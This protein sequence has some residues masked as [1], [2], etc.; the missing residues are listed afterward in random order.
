MNAAGAIELTI[1]RIGSGGDGIAAGPVYVPGALPG[2]RILAT[3]VA[4]RRDAT[5]A[6]LDAVLE[7]SAERVPPPC[8]HVAEGC[9]G[10]AVQHWSAPAVAAWKRSRLIEAL[11]RAGFSDP[12]VA[13]TVTVPPR[14]RRRAD[15]ALRRAADGSVCAGLHIGGG[16]EVIAVPHCQVLDPRLVAL[17]APLGIMLRSLGALRREGSAIVNLLDDGPDLLLRTD[18]PLDAPGRALLAGFAE[19][20]GPPRIAWA[21][22]DGV[23][24]T[25]AQRVPARL[26]LS[27]VEVVVPPGAFLQAAPQGE[28]AIIDAVLAGLPKK[29][30]ARARIAD[31]YAGLGTLS[32]PLSHRALVTGFEGDSATVAALGSAAARAGRPVTATRRDLARQPLIGAELAPFAAIVLDPPFAGAPEQMLAIAKAR[33]KRVIAV[34]C[35]PVALARD[36]RPLSAAGYKVIAATPVDQFLWSAQIEAVVVFAL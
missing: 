19:A 15:L 1:E 10:C 28:A 12:P 18:G 35:N 16:A 32:F 27:G 36:A 2:E 33:V 30:T 4:Q 29:L 25:A 7:P 8:P 13:E 6:R 9:G 26:N 3:A 20:Q 5:H 11:E 17:L 31:L 34:S 21:Q 22:R 23:A 14:T 24:E